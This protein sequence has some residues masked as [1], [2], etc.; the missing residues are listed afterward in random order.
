MMYSFPCFFSDWNLEGSSEIQGNI[1]KGNAVM[2]QTRHRFPIRIIIM[3]LLSIFILISGIL[4]FIGCGS[5]MRKV[6]CLGNSRVTCSILES[7]YW[8]ADIPTQDII[9]SLHASLL[10]SEKA[11]DSQ[12]PMGKSLLS[13]TCYSRQRG[14][15]IPSS[16]LVELLITKLTHEGVYQVDEFGGS[17]NLFMNAGKERYDPYSIHFLSL[18]NNGIRL[19]PTQNQLGASESL[20]FKFSN[21]KNLKIGWNE[22]LHATIELEKILKISQYDSIYSFLLN[23][24][25]C[26][27]GNRRLE[28]SQFFVSPKYGLIGLV[29]P[30]HD[31]GTQLC[32]LCPDFEN[33][34]A[35]LHQSSFE[36][37]LPVGRPPRNGPD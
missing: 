17:Y 33:H 14:K 30:H 8:L 2:V 6:E 29:F 25:E 35:K 37:H 21:G 5:D 10:R 13:F 22:D 12:T 24:G 3:K 9:D 26:G 32:W 28:Y 4:M 36:V 31:E 11:F 15:F 18:N 1:P 19:A 20:L 27:P 23:H 34:I 7:S 16:Y